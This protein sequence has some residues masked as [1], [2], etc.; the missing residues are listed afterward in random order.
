MQLGD[1]AVVIDERPV[2]RAFSLG[3]PPLGVEQL[4]EGDRIRVIGGLDGLHLPLGGHPAVVIGLREREVCV[5][6]A[7]SVHQGM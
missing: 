1:R 2:I 6:V 5:D 4:V 3:P 7:D